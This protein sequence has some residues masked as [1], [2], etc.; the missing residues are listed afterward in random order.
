[1]E[2]RQATGKT[3]ATVLIVGD[4]VVKMIWSSD[5]LLFRIMRI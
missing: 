1:M 2:K 3:A 4:A 5:P